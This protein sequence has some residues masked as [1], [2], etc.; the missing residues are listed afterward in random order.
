MEYSPRGGGFAWYRVSDS[1][2]A[3]HARPL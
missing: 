3:G 1:S 2:D